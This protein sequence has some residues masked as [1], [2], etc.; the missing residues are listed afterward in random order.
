MSRNTAVLDTNILVYALYEDAEHHKACRQLLDRA[1]DAEA[2]LCVTPQVLADGSVNEQ[3][4]AIGWRWREYE[5]EGIGVARNANHGGVSRGA[6]SWLL[7]FPDYEMAIAF[8]TNTNTEE[9]ADFGM[10]WRDIFEAFARDLSAA[11][12]P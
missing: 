5:V 11:D 10:A 1:Q 3:D 2:A 9:F 8:T 12:M 4:Y 6:Q 7:V